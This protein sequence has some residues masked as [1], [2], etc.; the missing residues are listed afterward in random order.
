VEP[1]PFAPPLTLRTL[2]EPPDA[3]PGRKKKSA[4]YTVIKRKG[5]VAAKDNDPAFD[6]SKG[7]NRTLAEQAQAEAEEDAD[8]DQ[9]SDGSCADFFQ[10]N[11]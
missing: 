4:A 2:A 5:K 11:F 6:I 9:L 7:A 3:T 10:K 1:V 8:R